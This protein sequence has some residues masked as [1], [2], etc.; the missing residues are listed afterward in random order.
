V[1]KKHQKK[2]IKKCDKK[3]NSKAMK[4]LF[5]ISFKKPFFERVIF[6]CELNFRSN[7]CLKKTF[8]FFLF[9]AFFRCFLFYFLQINKKMKTKEKKQQAFFQF[10]KIQ[11]K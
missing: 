5:K 11:T 4:V 1:I 8:D 3:E 2:S 7:F 9:K 10:S 6:F